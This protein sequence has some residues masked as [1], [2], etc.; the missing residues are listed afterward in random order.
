ME[1]AV[2]PGLLST[3]KSVLQHSVLLDGMMQA[4]SVIP[5]WE[6]FLKFYTWMSPFEALVEIHANTKQE[7]LFLL[8]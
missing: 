6:M 7:K 3:D 1:L 8:E 5:T 4:L 2:H